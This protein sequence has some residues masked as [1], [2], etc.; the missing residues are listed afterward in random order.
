MGKSW[1]KALPNIE[2]FKEC[3]RVLKA[4]AFALVMSAPRSDVQS[5]MAL[6]LEDAGFKIDFTPLYWAYASGFPKASNI[7]KMVDKRMGVEREIIPSKRH[8]G[9]SSD[10]FPERNN[11][12][13]SIGTSELEGSYGGFQPKPAVEVILVAMKPLSEK[14]YVDQALKNRKGITWLDDLRVPYESEGDME[15]ATPQGKCT[16]KDIHTGA[17]PDAGNNEE[18]KE[19]ERPEQQGRFPANLIVSDDVLNNQKVYTS[20]PAKGGE[21]TKMKEGFIKGQNVN[22]QAF[23][24]DSG[25]FSRYFSLDSWA[26][27]LPFLITPKAAKSEK[28]FVDGELENREIYPQNNSIERKELNATANIKTLNH[29]PTVKSVTLMSYLITLG[30]REGDIVLDPFAGSCTTG[31]AAHQLN[32]KWI[33]IEKESE[34]VEIGKARIKAITKQQ[35]L[36]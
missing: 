31:V 27:T 15:S 28:N 20:H 33:M 5:R 9:G 17:E 34:Y 23:Y 4:G 24:G 6:L 22:S 25:S 7:G 32:R 3:L 36:F 18:R 16:S 13:D 1:D 21:Y 14:T 35:K 19:F 2:I 11:K 12:T 30:S 29:H 26:K 8:G 10:I